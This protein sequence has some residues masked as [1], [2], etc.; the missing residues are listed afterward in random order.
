[1]RSIAAR[2]ASRATVTLLCVA[3]F[4]AVFAAPAS[5]HT[6]SGPRPTNFRTRILSISPPIPGVTMRVLELGAFVELSNTGPNDV[7]VLGYEGEPYLRVGPRGVYRNA[8]SAATY[9]NRSVKGGV[10]PQGVDT[11]PTAP[12]DWQKISDG[13]TARWHDHRSHWMGTGVPPQVANAPGTFQRIDERH[14]TLVQPNG[15]QSDVTMALDWVP[16]SSSVPWV[17]GAIALGVVGFVVAARRRWFRLLAVAIGILVVADAVHTVSYEM[18]RAGAFATRTNQFLEGSFVSILV[19]IAAVPTVI[20]LWRRRVEALYGA[21][22]VALM[23]ALVG[24]A[25]DLSALWKSQLPSA[26]PA[27]LTRME[28]VVALGLGAGVTIG[29]LYRM[30]FRERPERRATEV[31]AGASWISTLVVGLSDRELRRIVADLDVDEVLG[32][33]LQDLAA[34]CSTC[35]DAFPAGALVL[36][37]LADDDLGVHTWSLVSRDSSVDVEAGRADVVAA[38]LAMPFPLLLQLLA[39]T[40]ALED[41]ETAGRVRRT[42]DAAFVERV[43]PCF[44]ESA[45]TA[46]TDRASA[47]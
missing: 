1:M 25:T 11:S 27:W 5:A 42:G 13:H 46:P 36:D 29:T 3:A 44:A 41:A 19:W 33:A 17:I 45:P 2:V 23:V 26:G 6:L 38:E 30:I 21:L 16:A 39:G 20:F 40:V 10:I 8:H 34:R 22:L 18:S 4:L 7:V 24:G 37:V 32:M 31:R 14:I 47:S 28:V 9:I 43:A 12:P 15:T 35:A